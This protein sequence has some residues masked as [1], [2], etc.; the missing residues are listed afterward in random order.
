MKHITSALLLIAMLASLAACGG[1]ESKPSA[2]STSAEP[3]ET[4]SDFEK[5]IP[6]QDFGGAEFRIV[7]RVD[8]DL[9]SLHVYE[10]TAETENG[11]VIN[12]TVYARN[13]KISEYLNVKIVCEPSA[14]NDVTAL[15]QNAVM[16]GDDAY[17][18]VW[19]H[20]Q[21]VLSLVKS[22]LTAD[23]HSFDALSLDKPWWN[24]TVVENFTING[25]LPFAFCDIPFTS[26]LYIHCMFVNKTL[27]E[28]YLTED[29]YTTVN[30]G[31]WTLDKLLAVTSDTRRDV[32]GDSKFDGNDAYSFM[33][34]YGEMGIFS[35]S[36]AAE[37]LDIAADGSMTLKVM[38]ERMQNIVDKSYKLAYDNNSSYI[39]S[40]SLEKDIAQ[41]FAEGKSLFYSGFLSDPLLHFRDMKDDFALIPFPKYD[42]AQANYRTCISGGNGLLVIPKTVQNTELVGAVTEALA[43]E[44]Y[45]TLRP[46]VLETVMVGKLLRD[47]ESVEMFN[48]IIDG[49]TIDFDWL[50]HSGSTG[51]G[52]ILKDLIQKKSTDLASYVASIENAALAHY[53]TYIDNYMKD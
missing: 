26:M 27:A 46:A 9:Q 37:V 40:N 1:T 15:V 17:D 34:S 47:E 20:M 7:G 39:V 21:S 36:G 14:R 3:A 50:Y 31:K 38:S 41:M 44:S 8:G 35:T 11:D 33:A 19:N 18:L 2:D 49:I 23:L 25:K 5:Q 13:M 6:K 22:N 51:F 32:N 24:Q 29:I 10:M 16:A 45:Q 30:A 43:Y 52:R 4:L 53:Q 28:E 12:D 48:T 42:E